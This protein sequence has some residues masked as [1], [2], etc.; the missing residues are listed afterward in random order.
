MVIAYFSGKHSNAEVQEFLDESTRLIGKRE[1]YAIV[2]D[3]SKMSAASAEQRKMAADW[4]AQHNDSLRKYTVAQAYVVNS[5]FV[6]GL[7]TAIYWMTP[8]PYPYKFLGNLEHAY[9]WAAEMLARRGLQ[10]AP[11][12]CAEP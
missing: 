3:M 4:T 1:P 8:P 2:M 11:L 12:E 6:R 10:V 7:L 5:T 9:A